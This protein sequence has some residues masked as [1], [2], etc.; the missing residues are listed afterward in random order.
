MTIVNVATTTTLIHIT[1]LTQS[2]ELTSTENKIQVIEQPS[3]VAIQNLGSEIKVFASTPSVTTR[4]EAVE[5]T[6]TVERP[7]LAL[8]RILDRVRTDAAD[9]SYTYDGSGQLTSTANADVSKSFTYNGDGTLAAVTI[10]TAT[11]SITKTFSYDANGI[12]SVTVT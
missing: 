8:S 11:E 7:E 9:T 1:E 4:V 3:S 5:T 2:I 12:S 10:S 6:V